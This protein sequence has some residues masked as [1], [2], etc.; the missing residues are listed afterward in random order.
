VDDEVGRIL[1]M[2]RKRSGTYTVTWETQGSSTQVQFSDGGTEAP[3]TVK[4][5]I[6]DSLLRDLARRG[7]LHITVDTVL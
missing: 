5:M 7:K 4:A 1:N 2:R 6:A 3:D